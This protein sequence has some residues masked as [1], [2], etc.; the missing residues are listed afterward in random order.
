MKNEQILTYRNLFENA[1]EFA[2]FLDGIEASCSQ[3]SSAAFLYILDEDEP[4][5]PEHGKDDIAKDMPLRSKVLEFLT[6]RTM[7]EDDSNPLHRIMLTHG[8]R[9]LYVR[10]LY[11]VRDFWWVEIEVRELTTPG[12]EESWAP[13]YETVL[14]IA[15]LKGSGQRIR[16]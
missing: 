4:E 3:E 12:Q 6:D 2:L 1:V 15:Y 10:A 14:N 13:D 7:R 5:P 16:R 8:D 9:P 11:M